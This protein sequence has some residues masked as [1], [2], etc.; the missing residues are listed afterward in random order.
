MPDGEMRIHGSTFSSVY[1]YTGRKCTFPS[2]HF[3]S[4]ITFTKN[5]SSN[6]D[7]VLIIILLFY[8]PLSN[9]PQSIKNVLFL[10]SK[11]CFLCPEE[12]WRF[13][14]SSVCR[15]DGSQGLKWT[16]N[17]PTIKVCVTFLTQFHK[18][19]LCLFCSQK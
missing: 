16:A 17:P 9:L 6:F 10:F 8:V 2:S 19:L 18:R 14:V 12:M 4:L 13:L 7:L 15:A 3:I 5:P 11:Q 1:Q